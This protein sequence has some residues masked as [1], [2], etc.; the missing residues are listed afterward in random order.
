[1]MR[2]SLCLALFLPSI[3]QATEGAP[4]RY[5]QDRWRHS[6]DV[7]T[8]GG[9]VGGLGVATAAAGIALSED[10]SVPS[11][12]MIGTGAV[13]AAGGATV[14]SVVGLQQ[15]YEFLD[16]ENSAVGAYLSLGLVGLSGIGMLG[17]VATSPDDPVHQN[18]LYGSAAIAGTAIVPAALQ[19]AGNSSRFHADHEVSWAPVVAGDRIGAVAVVRF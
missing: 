1:M 6:R 19:L 3:A 11:G 13:A 4:E 7:S 5:V 8:L 2:L 18:L 10:P 17:A 14:M 9:V 16:R 15:R 12:L